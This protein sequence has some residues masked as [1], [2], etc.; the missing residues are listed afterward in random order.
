MEAGS[1][2][3]M[4]IVLACSGFEV[5]GV[6]C[7]PAASLTFL[8]S[9]SCVLGEGVV[10]RG[11]GVQIIVIKMGCQPCRSSDIQQIRIQLICFYCSYIHVFFFFMFVSMISF[12]YFCVDRYCKVKKKVEKK[13]RFLQCFSLVHFVVFLY[14]YY[15]YLFF[16]L[17]LLPYSLVVVL[18]LCFYCK[19][20]R[21]KSVIFFSALLLSCYGV[22]KYNV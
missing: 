4:R 2:R 1:V 19:V 3:C 5:V 12:W 10:G 13:L 17:Y 7:S 22:L 21:E 9:C 11:S 20:K 8:C 14:S 15:F 16:L 6:H 18:L